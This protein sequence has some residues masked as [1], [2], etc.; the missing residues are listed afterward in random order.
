MLCNVMYWDAQLSPSASVCHLAWSLDTTLWS[1]SGAGRGAR[2][3]RGGVRGDAAWC[4]GSGAA[5]VTT[6]TECGA[7]GDNLSTLWASVNT[8]DTSDQTRHLRTINF[9]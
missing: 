4:G 7:A 2:A 9:G 6:Y 5:A 3:G 1:H 8:R